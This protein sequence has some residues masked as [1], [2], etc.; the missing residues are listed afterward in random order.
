MLAAVA[1]GTYSSTEAAQSAMSDKGECVKPDESLKH[2]YDQKTS[3]HFKVLTQ[4]L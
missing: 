2:F 1:A 3:Q 4:K